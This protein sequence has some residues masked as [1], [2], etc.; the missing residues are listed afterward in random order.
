MSVLWGHKLEHPITP[1]WP[2][3]LPVTRQHIS[4]KY[5]ERRRSLIACDFE[6]RGEWNQLPD[7]RQLLSSNNFTASF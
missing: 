2:I 6:R 4:N 7:K 5:R 1:T 3:S